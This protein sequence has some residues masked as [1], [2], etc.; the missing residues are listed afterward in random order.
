MKEPLQF[1]GWIAD[2]FFTYSENW[3]CWHTECLEEAN[4][5]LRQITDSINVEL[6][7]RLYP[8]PKGDYH[9]VS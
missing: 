7:H 1:M 8:A 5:L 6:R 9:D 4:L 3:D 2:A